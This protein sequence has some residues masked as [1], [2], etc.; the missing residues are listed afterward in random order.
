MRAPLTATRQLA[1]SQLNDPDCLEKVRNFAKDHD[2]VV[3]RITRDTQKRRHQLELE[4]QAIQ[5]QRLTLL[6][7]LHNLINSPDRQFFSA[8]FQA[9]QNQWNE[10]PNHQQS[11]ET[12]AYEQ[13]ASK[14]ELILQQQVAKQN[15]EAEAEEALAMAR[16]RLALC[17]NMITQQ[18][19]Q[20]QQFSIDQNDTELSWVKPENEIQQ[21]LTEYAPHLTNAEHQKIDEITTIIEALRALQQHNPGFR[22]VIE[23]ANAAGDVHTLQQSQQAINQALKSYNWPQALHSVLDL[24]ALTATRQ[25]VEKRLQEFKQQDQ[26]AQAV[27]EEQLSV[28][29]AHIKQG[30]TLKAQELLDSLSKQVKKQPLSEALQQ[31]FR[32]LLAQVNE[33]SEWQQFAA[34][35]KK[36]QLC[37][38]MEALIDSHL[39]PA[40]LAEQIR[41]LQQQWKQLDQ[42]SPA[43]VKHLW[44]RFHAA[45]RQAYQPCDAYYK[46]LS[47]LRA[48]NLSQRELICQHLETYFSTLNW[49]QP[50]WRALEQIL[51]KAKHE[52]REFSPVDRAPGKLLQARF[53]Q[54]I[55]QADK[56]LQA[57]RNH[58]AIQ[59][60]ALVDEAQRL[61][62]DEDV[63]AAA[64]GIKALQQAWKSIDSTAKHKE[65]KLWEA[66]RSH[67]DQIFARIRTLSQD[68]H[69]S[70]QHPTDENPET[71]ARLLCIR[72]EILFNQPSPDNDQYLRMEYQMQRLQEALEPCS[73]TERKIAVQQ[74]IEEWHE[75]GFA[76]QFECL[77]ERFNTLLTHNE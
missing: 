31:Q 56:A 58:C 48:W 72:L 28:L 6:D 67:G 22:S 9:L 71:A 4:Q 26:T 21:L 77:H 5:Q 41:A 39:A 20:L 43:P 51:K 3:Y 13:L 34:I 53:Q 65:R 1:A 17:Q 70:D 35:S 66:F 32:N 7:N 62:Q 11:G 27:I 68:Q 47:R 29:D 15:A 25:Q 52:W 73:D 57:H 54:L 2:K 60:Q 12:E 63:V 23:Q 55:D 75:G 18:L 45:S 59:K 44:E 10:L 64:E 42:Q 46:E 76:E 30:E 8:R 40:A 38:A 37:I 16:Q 14:A 24:K 69:S 36:E 19:D 61:T 50:D 74:V 33:M 49:S